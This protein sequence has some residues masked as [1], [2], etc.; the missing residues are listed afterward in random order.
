MFKFSRKQAV[1][2]ILVCLVLIAITLAIKLT[3]P[4]PNETPPLQDP[5]GMVHAIVIDHGANSQVDINSIQRGDDVL[6]AIKSDAK[7]INQIPKIEGA[8]LY[9]FNDLE[10]L[11][12]HDKNSDGMIGPEDPIFNELMALSLRRA[13]P[14]PYLQPLAKSGIRMLVIEPRYLLA[15]QQGLQLPIGSS[16]GYAIMADS[17]KRSIKLVMVPLGLFKQASS[18]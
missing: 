3:P 18:L 17:S 5:T 1:M 7:A 6:L 11:L 13:H 12:I 4:T 9:L 15:I 2:F 14:E 16:I 8:K 10:S